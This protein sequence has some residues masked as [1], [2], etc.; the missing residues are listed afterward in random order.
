M[1]RTNTRSKLYKKLSGVPTP[2]ELKEKIIS[3]STIIKLRNNFQK[4]C[5]MLHKFLQEKLKGF[6]ILV[7][8]YKAP[9]KKFHPAFSVCGNPTR[10][11]GFEIETEDYDTLEEAVESVLGNIIWISEVQEHEYIGGCLYVTLEYYDERRLAE[12]A[13]KF[14]Q[15]KFQKTQTLSNGILNF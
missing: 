4:Q 7:D 13:F 12:V 14:G 2:T 3:S 9:K 10:T 5:R 1:L 6:M 8:S 11:T 15:R